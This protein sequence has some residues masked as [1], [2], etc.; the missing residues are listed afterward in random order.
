MTTQ[1]DP[2]PVPVT[3]AT[4]APDLPVG[5]TADTN[6]QLR[7]A[8]ER[9]NTRADNAEKQLVGVHL[10]K[11]G[12]SPEE[13]LGVAIAESFKGEVTF[14]NIA[15]HANDK[16]KYVFDASKQGTEA[17]VTTATEAEQLAAKAENVGATV[18]GAAQSVQPTNEAVEAIEKADRKIVDGEE[19]SEQEIVGGIAAKMA[20][21]NPRP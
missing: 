21:L 9:A 20:L 4:T 16:Y 13:G 15:S 5:E 10:G 8:L 6:P 14:D 7:E 3:E 17:A 1:P 18:M 12:L 11:M 2:Q 19:M